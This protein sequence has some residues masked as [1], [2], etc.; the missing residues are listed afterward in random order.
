MICSNQTTDNL[1]DTHL[2]E[3]FHRLE[4]DPTGLDAHQPGAK[5]DAGKSQA[6]ILNDFALALIAVAEVGTFGA[7]KY[8]RG[9]WQAVPNAIARYNDAG[10]RHKLKGC[11]E[12]HD[13]ESKLLHKAHEAWNVL[14]ELELTLRKHRDTA[15]TT[16]QAAQE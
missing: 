14:A 16:K 8:T 3:T 7:I 10:W 6:G 11:V 1:Q 15:V 4:A 2:A 13:H 9:G 5:L 12:T